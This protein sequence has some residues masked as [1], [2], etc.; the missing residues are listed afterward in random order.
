M[1]NASES[2]DSIT[3]LG[4]L[5][6]CMHCTYR[7]VR[8]QRTFH[9]LV[10]SADNRQTRSQSVS[11]PQTADRRRAVP[12]R[13]L[14]TSGGID[15]IGDVTVG[16]GRRVDVGCNHTLL[17]AL[18]CLLPTTDIR[19]NCNTNHISQSSHERELNVERNRNRF[20]HTTCMTRQ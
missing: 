19:N 20:I 10:H 12:T 4:V 8:T 11:T 13:R 6:Y 3:T 1:T 7:I 5:T 15:V 14:T 16:L 9:R 2:T 18:A 17:S